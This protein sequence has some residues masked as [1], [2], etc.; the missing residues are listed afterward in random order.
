MNHQLSNKEKKIK[1][2]EARR[3]AILW[4]EKE[5]RN[6][7]LKKTQHRVETIS[8]SEQTSISSAKTETILKQTSNPNESTVSSL[9]QTIKDLKIQRQELDITIKVLSKHLEL[10]NQQVSKPTKRSKPDGY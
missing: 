9:R 4:S 3:R 10:L 7:Q 5:L 6:R 2:A 1:R 8:L